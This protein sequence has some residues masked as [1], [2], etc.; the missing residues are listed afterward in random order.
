MKKYMPSMLVFFIIMGWMNSSMAQNGNLN[1]VMQCT[2]K[3]GFTVDEVVRVGR[4]IPRTDS[5]PNLVFYREPI[6]A[7]SSRAGSINVVR[8]WDNFEHMIMG[9]ESQTQTGPSRHFFAMVDCDGTRQVGLNR[10]ANEAGDASPY[11]GGEIN[12]S[13]VAIR[14]CQLNPGETMEDVQQ[15]LVEFDEENRASNDRSGYGFLQML[16][17]G[18]E[19]AMNSS[20]AIRVIGENAAGLAR[21]LDAMSWNTPTSS[22]PA[23]CGNLSLWKSYV[24]HWGN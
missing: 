4:A 6:V 22:D 14:Q 19:G 1:E 10:T 9:L 15:A 13:Y 12:E 18:T 5:G 17:S 8:Y 11:E 23:S 16:A 24:I 3:P 20:F 2:L 21:R 7:A